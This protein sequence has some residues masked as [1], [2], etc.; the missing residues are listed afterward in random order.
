MKE[1]IKK[2]FDKI[3]NLNSLEILDLVNLIS[4]KF[5]ISLKEKESFNQNNNMIKKKEEEENIKKNIII[6][7]IG[8][9]SKISLIRMIREITNFNLKKAKDISENLPY[10]ITEDLSEEKKYKDIKDKLIKIGLEVE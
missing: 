4:K 10:E 3:L 8:N 5:N 9:A 7:S 2:L 6:K 1:K